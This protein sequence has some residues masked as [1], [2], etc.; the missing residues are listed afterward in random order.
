[1]FTARQCEDG[2]DAGKWYTV[3]IER[4]AVRRTGYCAVGCGG[5]DSAQSALAHH[6][7]FQLDRETDMWLDRRVQ[8][9]CEICG[10]GT[11]LRARLG[12]DTRLFVLCRQHQSTVSLKLLFERRLSQQPAAPP[13]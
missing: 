3:S 4:Q 1:M 9:G 7:Q 2:A 13:R 6:L 10:A 5:H 8:S 12:R 11:T